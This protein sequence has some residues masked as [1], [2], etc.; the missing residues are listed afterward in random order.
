MIIKCNEC[1]TEISNLAKSCPKCGCPIKSNNKL[2]ILCFVLGIIATVYA[3]GLC[4]NIYFD[5]YNDPSFLGVTI[6]LSLLS[7]IFGLISIR[8][9]QNKKKPIIGIILSSF[10]IIISIIATIVK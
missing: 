4:I 7:I 9:I 6:L 2:S 1:G 5:G 8:K 10:S 3:Y